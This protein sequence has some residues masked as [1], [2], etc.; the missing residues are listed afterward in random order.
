MFLY[1]AEIGLIPR[2]E[3]HM[4]APVPFRAETV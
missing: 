1:P 2:L 3:H 4:T